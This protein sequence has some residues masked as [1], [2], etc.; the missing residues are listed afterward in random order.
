MNITTDDD[1]RIHF[2]E[3]RLTDEDF[4]SSLTEL[5]KFLFTHLKNEHV[6]Y[7]RYAVESKG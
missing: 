5:L 1:W 3:R 7:I 4:F 2:D 6:R